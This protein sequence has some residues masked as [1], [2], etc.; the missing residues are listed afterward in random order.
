MGVELD[1]LEIQVQSSADQASGGINRLAT[2]L[3]SLRKITKGGVGLTTVANQLS[4]LNT[5]LS[6]I[7]IN[8][9]KISE[10][11]KALNSLSSVQKAA[12]LISTVNALKKIPDI[13]DRLQ[14]EDLNKFATQMTRVADSVRPLANEMQKVSNG[15]SAFP[16]RIQKIIAGNEGLSASNNKTAKS[17]N[18]L[19]SFAAK[20]SVAFLTA[21]RAADVISGWIKESNDYVENLNLFTVAMGEY[22]QEAQE[23]A[24][25]VGE[26]MGIDPS[27]WMRNQGVFMTLISGFG[28]VSEDAAFM[29]KNLTQLGYDLSSFFNI[30]VED[31]MQ[32]LQSGISGELEPL[33]RLG[34]DLSQAKLESIALANGITTSVSAMTQA[35]KSQLRY[36]AIMTQ[37]TQAQGD[38]ART[39][40]APA[41]QLRILQA[42]AT[43]A[44]RALGNIFIPALNAI[45]PYAIA[46]L[47][48]I[49]EVAQSIANLFGFKLPE[50]DYSGITSVSSSVDDISDSFDGATGS[51]KKLQKQL[52]GFDELNVINGTAD[53][54]GGSTGG[55]ATGGD[56]GLDLPGYDFLG[57]MVSSKTS[58]IFEDLKDEIKSALELV[59]EIGAG[60]AAWKVANKF[61]RSLET[62]VTNLKKGSNE[63]SVWDKW[64]RIATGV[65][66]S[67]V[68]MA[69][70]YDAGY[71]IGQGTAGFMDYLKAV[72]GPIA[73]GI[74]GALIGS[75]VAPGVGTAAGFVIGLSIGVVMEIVGSV[76]GAKQAM[77]DAFYASD[78]GEGI[79]ELNREIEANMTTSADLRVRVANI[80]GEVDDQT[81]ADFTLAKQLINEIFD[82]DASENKTAAEIA[83][84]QDKITT[85]NGLNLADLQGM[86]QVTTD[87]Y[88]L[89]TRDAVD[90][91]MD[92]ILKLY[93][94][95]ALK[96]AYI[97][98][99]REQYNAAQEMQDAYIR[100]DNYSANYEETER[101][102]DDA[103]RER[104]QA[105]QDL[106]DFMNSTGFSWYTTAAE[107]NQELIDKY[108]E[109]ASKVDSAQYT[110][111][112]LNTALADMDPELEKAKEQ[113]EASQ[114]A[115]EEATD[116][117]N[118]LKQSLYD[119]SEVPGEL[120]DGLV[121]DG[122]NMTKGLASGLLAGGDEA[123]EAMRKVN[124]L[125]HKTEREFNQINSPSKLYE[126]DA[127]YTMQGFANGITNNAYL[128]EDA[129]DTMLN[130]LLSKLETFASRFRNAINSCLS[131][132][133][134][135]MNNVTVDYSGKIRYSSMPYISIPRFAS[136]GYPS[137][138]QIFLAREAGPELVGSIG[139]RTAVAN[140]E[141]ITEGIARAVY[142]AMMR[143][144]SEDENGNVTV[145]IDGREIFSVV[146]RQD[147]DYRKRT[148]QS[149]FTY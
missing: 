92:S 62:V 39:L 9:G 135:A 58:K 133:S 23:Y 64:Q 77:L 88:I 33:R 57:D 38:M 83:I 127:K 51:A 55:I 70:S 45:L 59:L 5:A 91:T 149:A 17:F 148:G 22:A 86:F 104:T 53:G 16:I 41:N 20:A 93:Q 145:V 106:T 31:A 115:Y 81:M 114:P 99:F 67:I 132:M 89:P 140:N 118:D 54:A 138:G 129:M 35:E 34:Y 102:L 68:G 69:I 85:L 105:Q 90:A 139:S 61:I 122:T 123:E 21:R 56:L 47:Q 95:E 125:L 100:L 74:G 82:M 15:F 72:L 94:T 19:N 103:I 6:S 25:S 101:Q 136:G 79:A 146:Q 80:T 13:T 126:T 121:V 116:K 117:V 49:R 137:H 60:I 28:V 37:V 46:F 124:D 3:E 84:I 65:V 128:V 24:E 52:M 147:E 131:G 14:S 110:Q 134:T 75:A 27:A 50:V 130:S 71:A 143:A 40:S 8:T 11:E 36:L 42:S 109:L 107:G 120:Q 30:S 113:L 112:Q 18:L 119:L 98:A 78:F 26:I 12:G 10:V 111:N 4:K 7:T 2:S 108:N 1:T 76:K 66:I 29:S 144:R 141:Q 44:S 48:V 142:A 97:E 96:E 32:K 63:L 43:Q 73:N 87:S